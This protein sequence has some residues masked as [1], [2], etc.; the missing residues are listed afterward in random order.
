MRSLLHDQLAA[1]DNWAI[2]TAT[3]DGEPEITSAIANN[4]LRC[5]LA[6]YGVVEL[7]GSYKN[8]PQGASFLVWGISAD[9]AIALGKRFGQESVLLP[10][11]LVYCADGSY[12]RLTDLVF[13]AAARQRDCWSETLDGVAFSFGID[14]SQRITV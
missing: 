6:D 12:H 3:R 2:L 4:F 1:G 7:R 10:H 9:D 8:V 13:D 5:A 11:G 14:W